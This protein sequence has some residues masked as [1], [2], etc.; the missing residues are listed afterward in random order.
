M[1]KVIIVT[2]YWPPSGGPAVQRWLSFANLLSEKGVKV[3]IIT[4]DPDK[5]SFPLID[6]TLQ[7]E[8][9]ESIEVK[10]IP[11]RDNYWIYKKVFG[12][13]KVPTSGFVN[14]SNTFLQKIARFIRGNFFFPDPRKNWVNGAVK[15]IQEILDKEDF[16][17]I[18]TAGPPHSTHFVGK[19]IK[20]DNQKIN[21]IV[22]FHDAWTDV[23]YY[24]KLYKTSLA[25]L[26]D[27]KM[28]RTILE[29]A[30]Y[31]LTVGEFLRKVLV[32]KTC[33]KNDEKFRT[34]SMGFDQNLNYSSISDKNNK[35]HICYT[36][37]LDEAYQPWIIFD[38][39]KELLDQ[40]YDIVLVFV[41]LVS[42]SI[43]TYVKEIGI[44]SNVTYTGYL[45]HSESIRFLRYADA[46]L[47]FSPKVKTERIIIPGKLYEYLAARKPIIN[48]GMKDSNT[49]KII[50]ECNAGI[51]VDRSEKS[52]ITSFFT[53]WL[54]GMNS[55]PFV[56]NEEKIN[57]YS[58][59]SEVEKI[60]SL[61]T[62]SE[63]FNPNKSK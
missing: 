29:G 20:R 36:G 17:N 48:I 2:Y 12:R 61:L 13:G 46:L 27:K 39:T 5:A 24:E 18:I 37:T 7:Y 43:K 58:R 14:E 33:S 1:L 4:P 30:D 8:I 35:L 11:I 31:V 47:L 26:L 6:T 44:E 55:P 32:E 53:K 62:F 28:E 22:D 45:T 51:N 56:F 3:I 41:G 25:R 10:K 49:A 15:V 34:V 57:T 40:G 42:D 19:K 50:E 16:A 54:Q 60:I 38:S 23:W 52:E 63:Q 21:W 59:R 9:S